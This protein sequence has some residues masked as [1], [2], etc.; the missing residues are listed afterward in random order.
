MRGPFSLSP[1]KV[2]EINHVKSPK[3][4]SRADEVVFERFL[5]LPKE[6]V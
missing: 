2:F 1:A 4:L 5:Q 3:E 6:G